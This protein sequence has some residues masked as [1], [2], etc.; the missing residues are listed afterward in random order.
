MGL[1]ISA[2]KGLVDTGRKYD[3]EDDYNWQIERGLYINPDFPHRADEFNGV[4]LYSFEGEIHFH[5]GSYSGYS[6]WRAE[7]ANLAGYNANYHDPNWA[8]PESGPFVELVNFSDCE[9]TLGTA[10][11]KKLAKDFADFQDTV[12]AM[13]NAMDNEYFKQLYTEWREAFEYASDGGAVCF[14]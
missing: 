10:V 7:L 8:V 4:N 2:F 11:C 6:H 12:D 9:G 14:H 1:D 13:P 5:A 3:P